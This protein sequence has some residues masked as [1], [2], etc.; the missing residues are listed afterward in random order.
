VLLSTDHYAEI[1]CHLSAFRHR[2]GHARPIRDGYDGERNPAMLPTRRETPLPN[3][4]AVG[5]IPRN[6]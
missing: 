6:S 4:N 1:R 2:V 5:G 3:G